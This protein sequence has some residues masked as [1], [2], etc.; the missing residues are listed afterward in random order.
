MKKKQFESLWKGLLPDLPGFTCKGKLLYAEPVEH[1]LQGF[2]GDD[3][4]FDP[5]IFTVWA[6]ALPLYVPTEYVYFH[7]GNRL[8]DERGREK[9]WNIQEPDLADKVLSSI[10]QEGLPFLDR[11][12]EPIQVAT[13]MQQSPGNALPRSLEII[14]Y[15]LAMAGDF[16]GAEQTLDRLMNAIDTKILWQVEVLD[17]A[18][19]LA[20]KL[21]N[22]PQE[23]KQ[24]L[25][26]W[27]QLSVKN[28]GLR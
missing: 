22:D 2:C 1:L 7:P 14:A 17:R 26:E 18:K 12:R 23:A 13:Y 5:T 21:N 27:E 10:K 20:G 24:Q 28:L 15:S 3:S 9:W 11:I 19:L 6:F 25:L 16:A 8:S 4:S